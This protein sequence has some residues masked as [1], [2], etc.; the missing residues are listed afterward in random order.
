[1]RKTLLV[2]LLLLATTIG[3]AQKPWRTIT[4]TLINGYTFNGHY[5][6]TAA[7]GVDYEINKTLSLDAWV[8]VNYNKSYDGGWSSASIFFSKPLLKKWRWGLGIKYGTGNINTPFADA[9]QDKDMI[10]AIRISR[11][12]HLNR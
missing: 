4:P 3:Y 11:R 9:Y 8:G 6:M 12:F 7:V 1:M 5:V 10:Y 2:L